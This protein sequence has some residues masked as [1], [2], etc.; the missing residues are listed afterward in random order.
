MSRPQGGSPGQPSRFHAGIVERGA[1]AYVCCTMVK[2]QRQTED[3]ANRSLIGAILSILDD[4]NL[5]QAL[6]VLAPARESPDAEQGQA[7]CTR[8]VTRGE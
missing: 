3:S 7:R 1:G 6:R 4:R 2:T 8:C 5:E